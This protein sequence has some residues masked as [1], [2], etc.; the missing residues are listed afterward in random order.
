METM[1]AMSGGTEEL[2]CVFPSVIFT[3]TL[4]TV[5]CPSVN[6][7]TNIL[8]TNTELEDEGLRR[9][10]VDVDAFATAYLSQGG[11]TL[12]FHLCQ[13]YQNCSSRS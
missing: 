8:T 12:T 7:H 11:A 10:S 6:A 13:F 1:C 2:T 3:S 9:P 5:F 4:V